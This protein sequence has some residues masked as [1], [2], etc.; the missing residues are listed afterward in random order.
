MLFMSIVYKYKN[1]PRKR[2]HAMRA[3]VYT[4]SLNME[5]V[6]IILFIHRFGWQLGQFYLHLFIFERIELYRQRVNNA[7]MFEMK[8]IDLPVNKSVF[9]IVSD[10]Q[11]T[12]QISR[13]ELSKAA[14]CACTPRAATQ[15][16]G[17]SAEHGRSCPSP[18][19]I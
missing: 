4:K 11:V 15:P 12:L 18:P 8:Y 6:T 1:I 5:R 3:A 2:W 14:T 7:Y 17:S 13:R 16:C 10:Y 19:H 9:Y